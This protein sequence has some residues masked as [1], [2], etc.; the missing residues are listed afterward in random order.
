MITRKF[1]EVA[2]TLAKFT[3]PKHGVLEIIGDYDGHPA[4]HTSKEPYYKCQ[5][6]ESPR[7]F[8]MISKSEYTEIV[9]K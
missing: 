9:G 2:I 4:I 3:H 8:F 6:V 1:D 5:Q 7:N